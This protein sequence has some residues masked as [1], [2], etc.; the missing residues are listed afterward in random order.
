MFH[1]TGPGLVLLLCLVEVAL[2]ELVDGREALQMNKS[3][4]DHTEAENADVT[5]LLHSG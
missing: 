2:M 3:H 1:T 5:G 4:S